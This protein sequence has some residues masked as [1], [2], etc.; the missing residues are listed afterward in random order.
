MVA[1]AVM[2][3]VLSSHTADYYD[4]S[5]VQVT[6]EGGIQ[7]FPVHGSLRAV[8]L[9]LRICFLALTIQ[10]PDGDLFGGASCFHLYKKHQAAFLFLPFRNGGRFGVVCICLTCQ[11]GDH[12]RL[13]ACS[14]A[15]MS[16]SSS[17]GD[18][19]GGNARN[20]TVRFW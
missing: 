4:Q 13:F 12:E 17:F 6:R 11:R 3:G 15:I 2:G 7:L 14:V 19:E 10:T 9:V 20:G 18:R 8:I 5:P 16:G 1:L